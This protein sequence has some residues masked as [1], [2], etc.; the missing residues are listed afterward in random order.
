MGNQSILF[1]DDEEMVLRGIVRQQEDD[2]DITTSLC[3]KKALRIIENEGP[4]A[5]V[6]SDMRMPEMNGVQFLKQVKKIHPDSV[7]M[8]LT[9]FAELN[10]TIEAVNEGN[11]F[12]FLAKPCQEDAMATALNAGLRQFSLIE[13]EREL[14][15][16]TLHGSVNVLTDVLSLIN[17]LAFGQTTRVRR[18]V[19]GI[20]KRVD[21][22][23]PWQIEIAAMLSSIGCLTLPQSLL[24]R[25]FEGGIL[26]EEED[27]QFFQASRIGQ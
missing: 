5:V 19:D 16:E 6:V 20:V 18:T 7:R 27:E 15:E 13:A 12:R 11:I 25:K 21:I 26:S 14:V 24:E 1:V 17:P 10:T 22:Q 3:P 2:F 8:I 9:G 4:F 23:D